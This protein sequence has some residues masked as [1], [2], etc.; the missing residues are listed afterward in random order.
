MLF[1]RTRASFL[2]WAVPVV[3]AGCAIRSTGNPPL[4]AVT[5]SPVADVRDTHVPHV[6][7]TPEEA[8]PKLVMGTDG[9]PNARPAG[10][11]KLSTQSAP[12]ASKGA[13]ESPLKRGLTPLP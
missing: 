3:L 5:P 8:P 2:L 6:T 9:T 4:A 1:P 7:G 11:T 12:S 10:F 13:K